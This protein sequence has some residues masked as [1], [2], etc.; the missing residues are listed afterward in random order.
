MK[1]IFYLVLIF[2]PE[3]ERKREEGREREI[4]K[5]FMFVIEKIRNINK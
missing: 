5:E 2:H 3:R 1:N 4:G